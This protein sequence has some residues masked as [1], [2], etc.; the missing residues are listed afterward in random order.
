MDSPEAISPVFKE[1][2]TKEKRL[3]LQTLFKTP[4]Y[5]YYGSLQ[6]LKRYINVKFI[7]A[8]ESHQEGVHWLVG[9]FKKSGKY[10]SF[11]LHIKDD[12]LS[13]NE[14]LRSMKK[15]LESTIESIN[16]PH[17]MKFEYMKQVFRD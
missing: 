15:I 4:I 13:K 5:Q 16:R 1:F 17:K 11:T 12:G 10:Y 3:T 14:V 9:A 2:F 7:F 8:Q 6:W